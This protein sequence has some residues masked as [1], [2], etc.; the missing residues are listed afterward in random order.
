MHLKKELKKMTFTVNHLVLRWDA[1]REEKG[2]HCK[3]DN[4]LFGPFRI[5]VVLDN[6]TFVLKN[7]DDDELFGG[8]TNVCFLKHIY[9]FLFQ[10]F[11]ES[12]VYIRCVLFNPLVDES[13]AWCER[14]VANALKRGR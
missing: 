7:L 1:R 12:I 5:A 8:P 10:H 13:V 6:N 2:K 4:L 9:T 3:F 14:K 11:L